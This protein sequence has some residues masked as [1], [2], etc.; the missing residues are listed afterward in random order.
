[1]LH[2]LCAPPKH[3]GL[4]NSSLSSGRHS[5]QKM[6][7]FSLVCLL[8]KGNT[9]TSLGWGLGYFGFLNCPGKFYG[10]DIEPV[11]EHNG[12]HYYNV[13]FI[14][15]FLLFVSTLDYGGIF[16]WGLPWT[17]LPGYCLAILFG[18]SLASLIRAAEG[19]EGNK[20]T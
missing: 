5:F 10:F 17:P 16:F 4:P 7:S 9:K 8:T 11:S 19:W 2:F 12:V 20:A 14:M 13:H 15:Y 3:Q 1:M 6:P 18:L